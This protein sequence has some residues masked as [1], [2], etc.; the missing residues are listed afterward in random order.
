VG[1]LKKINNLFIKDIFHGYCLKRQSLRRMSRASC[2]STSTICHRCRT[3]TDARTCSPPLIAP[4]DRRLSAFDRVCSDNRIEH[5]LI[6]PRRP[7]TNGRFE[8][9]NGRIADVLRTHYFD[10]AAF[11]QVTLKRFVYLYN[12]HIP[13]KGLRHKTPLRIL[14]YWHAQKPHLFK[15]NPRNHPGPET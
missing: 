2:M 14:K 4:P 1:S 7:Q 12:H 11:L 9:F 5:R 13:Q 10:S 6:K 15:K 3:R 8:R